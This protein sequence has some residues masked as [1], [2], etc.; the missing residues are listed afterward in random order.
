[1]PRPAAPALLSV[2]GLPRGAWAPGRFGPGPA[3][4]AGI[5]SLGALPGTASLGA[6][7]GTASLAALPGITSFGALVSI[8]S[9][10]ALA[11]IASLG[12]LPGT[13][14]LGALP[15]IASLGALALVRAVAS[16]L[17]GSLPGPAPGAA[18]GRAARRLAAPAAGC[19][20]RHALPSAINV[21]R[22]QR[23]L[24]ARSMTPAFPARLRGPA[25]LPI[26]PSCGAFP[27]W[28]GAR[29]SLLSPGTTAPL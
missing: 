13:A 9:L 22:P 25:R 12:A 26:P 3:P 4:L 2:S 15:G 29:S 21:L 8:A 14:S 20:A 1:V 5:A 18:T 11:G 23:C 27:L 10:G 28:L 19:L 16:P 6:L 7:P 24:R 17:C